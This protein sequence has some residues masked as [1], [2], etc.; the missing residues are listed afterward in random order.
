MNEW[1]NESAHGISWYFRVSCLNPEYGAK[2]SMDVNHRCWLGN[3][4][5]WDPILEKNCWDFE[6]LI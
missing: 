2:Q 6:T 1:M 4:K 5:S 3:S